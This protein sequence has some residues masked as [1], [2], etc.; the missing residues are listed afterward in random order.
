MSI[1]TLGKQ[2]LIYG[3]GTILARIVT[4]LLLPLYTNVFTAE[5]YGVVSLAYA[6]I[7]FAIMLYRYG[8]DAALMKYYIEVEGEEKKKYFTT[9]FISQFVTSLI[10]SGLLFLSASMIAPIILGGNYTFLLQMVAII[11]FF[12]VLWMLPLLILRAEEKPKHYIVLS[13]LNVVLLMSFNIYLVVYKGLGIQGVLIGNI[14]ASGLLLLA[15][16]PIILRNIKI[17]LLDRVVLKQVLRFGLPFFPAGIFTMIME[18]SDRYLL[19]WMTNT[20]LVGIYSAGNKL[21]MFGMLLVLGFNMGWTP[22]FLKIGKQKDAPVIFS[23]VA[24]YFLGISGFF[25]VFISLWIDYVVRLNIGSVTIFGSEFWGSTQVVPLILLGYYFSGL[26]VLQLPGVFILN[27]TNWMPILRGVGATVSIVANLILIPIFDINGAAMGKVIAYFCMATSIYIMTKNIYP[28]PFR[29]RSIVFPIIF[30]LITI[31]IPL[32]N[33]L[34][35]FMTILY[36][37]LWVLLIAEKTDLER[38][39]RLYKK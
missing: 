14:A 11:L 35:L 31:A 38:I 13:L 15:T 34:R 3:I 5:E 29:F 4:F 7:G 17:S 2:T 20:S 10:F 33:E 24:T 22:Y 8:M 26:F 12:D 39:K 1:K 37:V 18:L 32:S 28:I 36:P 21:G 27:K 16:L 9:I 6:F 23:R 19:E 25:I 30:M